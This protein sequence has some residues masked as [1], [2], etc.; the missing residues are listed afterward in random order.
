MQSL[1]VWESEARHWRCRDQDARQLSRGLHEVSQSPVPEPRLLPTSS[2]WWVPLKG[3][4]CS[5]N[6]PFPSAFEG[7]SLPVCTHPC[8]VHFRL[9][10]LPYPPMFCKPVNSHGAGRSRRDQH[11]LRTSLSTFKNLKPSDSRIWFCFFSL[12]KIS[13]YSF[14]LLNCIS[15]WVLSLEWLMGLQWRK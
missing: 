9:T 6:S 12:R 14:S 13:F 8:G 10:Y 1:P 7:W 5:V 15:L 2:W 3:L 4:Q 11:L